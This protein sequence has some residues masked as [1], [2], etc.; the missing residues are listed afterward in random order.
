[1][2]L[3]DY[4]QFTLTDTSI[5]S[6]VCDALFLYN[7][8]VS[9]LHQRSYFQTVLFQIGFYVAVIVNFINGIFTDTGV[10]IE[11]SFG[12]LRLQRSTVK[13]HREVEKHSELIVS[14]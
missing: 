1:M 10:F 9:N 12:A 4:L 5:E 11:F 3:L 13:N 2:W 14:L 8:F 7:L 6:M